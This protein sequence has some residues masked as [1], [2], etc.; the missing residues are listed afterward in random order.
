MPWIGNLHTR[1]SHDG[2]D[3]EVD[4]AG[5]ESVDELGS[6]AGADDAVE[7][8]SVLHVHLA[9]HS[10]AILAHF[11][12]GG[13]VAGGDDGGVDVAAEEGLSNGKHFSW[14]EMRKLFED[15]RQAAKQGLACED[16]DG[17]GAISNFL[18]L[19]A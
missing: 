2:I 7:F 6:D 5:A 3:S 18:V 17:C 12:Q 11:L 14:R 4:H 16:N 1:H 9:R 13:V 8:S 15:H 10:L 19:C